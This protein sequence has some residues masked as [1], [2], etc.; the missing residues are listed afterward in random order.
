MLSTKPILALSALLAFAPVALAQGASVSPKQTAVVEQLIAG[1]A[2]KA[3]EDLLKSG[4]KVNPAQALTF[5][6]ETGREF[7][8]KRRT[9]EEHDRTCSGCH[10]EDPAREGKHVDTKKAIKPLAP[11]ANAERFTDA[12]K[13][14]KNFAEHCVDLY[15]RDCT[16]SEKGHFITY[17]MSAK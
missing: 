3:K 1:Y 14:E 4:R 16:A 12:K 17:L 7:Y 13:V 15:Q 9:W 5:S 10:T 2:A 8:L 11:K 6:A